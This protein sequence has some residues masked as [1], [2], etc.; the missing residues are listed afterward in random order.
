MT[1]SRILS[2]EDPEVSRPDGK[3]SDCEKGCKRGSKAR[4]ARKLATENIGSA[5][6]EFRRALSS[7]PVS[8]PSTPQTLFSGRS[9]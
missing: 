1:I 3:D 8:S 6:N 2:K 9:A 4:L 5:K 7:R